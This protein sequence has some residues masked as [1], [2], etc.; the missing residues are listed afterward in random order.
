[1]PW[2]G[3]AVL[4]L[5]FLARDRKVWFGMAAMGLF[6]VPLLFL[7]GRMFSAY[8]YVPFIGLAMALC[9]LA[10]MHRREWMA[11]FF[12]AWIP[13]SYYSLRTQRRAKLAADDEVRVYL[14]T[15]MDFARRHP[16]AYSYVFNMAP[17]NFGRWGIEAAARYSERHGEIKLAH[18]DEPAA[19][20]L[21][22]DPHVVLLNWRVS[23]AKLF[24][25]A[26]DPAARNASFIQMGFEAPV[27]QLEDGW[28]ASDANY[29]WSKPKAVAR[30][31]RPE[32][33]RVLELTVN[34]GVEQMSLI[35]SFEVAATL[36]GAALPARRFGERG[37]HT[38]RWELP[39]A[40]PGDVRV[41]FR[42]TP[43]TRSPHD[44]RW[45]GI[46]AVSFG[47]PQP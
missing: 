27:W 26:R 23:P 32:G 42:V 46:A 21:M 44:G 25:V 37:W 33:A 15:L 45:L 7:P 5:P 36:N 41:E 2:A 47:F 30:L 20:E 3:F 12:A 18:V 1:V 38:V 10:E 4:A 29:R 16:E 17:A 9:G 40:P 34:C 11:L 28:Y 39:P 31:F 14:N 8:C 19:A 35:G 22:R 24:V 43:E 13:I 6:F